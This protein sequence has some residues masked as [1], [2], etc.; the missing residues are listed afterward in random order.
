MLLGSA[1]ENPYWLTFNQAKELGGT[2]KKGAKSALVCYFNWILKDSDGK[3]VKDPK[4]AA[5][6]FPV[7]KY[8][9]VFSADDIEGI[10]FEYPTV[11]ELNDNERI[12]QCETIVQ[13]TSAT[14]KH[15]GDR[16]YW[17]PLAD[18]IQMPNLKQFDNSETYYATLFHELTHWTGHESRLNR[19]MAGGMKSKTY[20]KE[21]LVAEMGANFFN[22]HCQIETKK[23]TKNSAAYLQSW[24]STLKGDSK[25]IITAAAQAQKAFD[26]VMKD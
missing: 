15:G 24:I 12:E 26:F 22:S 5:T 7:L 18:F 23:M 14:I 21:E 4:L 25:L 17:T 13:S 10:E 1:S 6:K 3:T 20:A 16:A 11:V 2:I 19:N 9:R 8:Y